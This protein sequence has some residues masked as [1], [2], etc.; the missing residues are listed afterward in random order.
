MTLATSGQI[1]EPPPSDGRISF[2][3]RIGITGHIDLRPSE[4]VNE[5]LRCQIARIQDDLL[6]IPQ[7]HGSSATPTRLAIVSQLANGPDRL[8]VK[9]V[10]A[11]AE[12]RGQAAHLEVILPMERRRYIRRQQ[13]EGESL[14]EFEQLLS[15]AAWI[16]E[17]SKEVV[18]P[19]GEA[20]EAAAR[21]LVA[22]CDVLVAIWRG[23][24][25]GGRGGTAETLVHAAWRRTP[26]IWIRPSGEPI[27]THN[28]KRGTGESFYTNVQ[29]LALPGVPAAEPP[30]NRPRDV[31]SPLRDEY[32][33]LAEFNRGRLPAGLE[34][35]LAQQVGEDADRAWV[36][37]P[38]L[39]ASTLARRHQ[40]VFKRLAAVISVFASMAAAAL[41]VSVSFSYDWFV[42]WAEP[43]FLVAAGI[44]FLALR[45]GGFHRRWLSCRVLAE[46]L[47]SAYY[48]APLGVDF[49]RTAGL[50]GVYVERHSEDWV[51][52]AFVEVWN[53]RPRAS[54]GTRLGGD[55][56]TQVKRRLAEEWIGGQIRFHQV[57]A[58]HDERLGYLLSRAAALSFVMGLAFAV[59]HALELWQR[60]AILLSITLPAVGASLGV[61][62]TVGQHR[63]LSERYRR[64]EF[65]LVVRQTAILDAA[66]QAG[67][68]ATSLDAARIIAQETG[69]WFGAMWFHDIEQ[70]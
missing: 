2:R 12:R 9:E 33:G 61:F 53:R 17:P 38:L 46:R 36:A 55:E 60:T 13:F 35:Q 65:D 19:D 48:L 21:H 32:D 66:S 57:R 25:T 6:D 50:E 59:L 30:P 54:P 42:T 58:R 20:Y 43:G 64:M 62:V 34:P 51:L 5:T 27:V 45:S 29:E 69:D 1:Q 14:A 37:A 41:G 28:L 44:A 15:V 18:I 47:R 22:R 16:S 39:R 3:I 8:I 4:A 23:D 67:L 56:L 26:C 68:A 31:L 7:P 40:R 63:A 49:R 11:H 52:R 24:E 10:M 70:L